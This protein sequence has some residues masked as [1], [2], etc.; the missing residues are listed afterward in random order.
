M[1]MPSSKSSGSTITIPYDARGYLSESATLDP[2][3]FFR[4]NLLGG[5]VEYDVDLSTRNCG[6]IA[7]FYLVGMPGK[8]SNG[9]LWNTDG[10]YY[11]DAN[12]VGGN[13]CP[14]FDIMEA[15]QWAWQS[16][17]HSCDAPNNGFYNKCN[18]AGACWQNNVDKLAYNDYG[19]GSNFKIDTSKEFH[20][21]F[22]FSK[23]GDQFSAFTVNLSQDGKTV[24]MKGDCGTNK[25]M[26]IDIKNGMAFAISSWSTMSNWLWKSRCQAQ[27]CN[28]A[29][30]NFKNLKITTGGATPSPSPTPDPTPTP[31]PSGDYTY[32]NKCKSN[33]DGLCTGESSCDCRWSWPSSETY[34]SPDADCRCKQ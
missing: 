13:F 12:K 3:K 23:S 4:P 32:G 10:Y 30:L 28:K 22:D 11:C 14:E 5:S 17:A 15:N 20:V 19:P 2:N 21:K 27:S 26:T 7:A 34:K 9:E 8:K 6:C 1:A 25:E 31:T 33:H 16:T 18:R 29:D 24:Q